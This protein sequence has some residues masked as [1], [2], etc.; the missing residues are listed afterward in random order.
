[1]EPTNEPLAFSDTLSAE[2]EEAITQRLTAFNLA[3][4]GAP[5]SAPMEPQPVQVAVRDAAGNLVGGLIGTSHAIPYWLTVSVIWVDERVRGQGAGSELMRRA[6]AIARQRGCRYAR[7]ATSQYQA[8]G[9]Y[10]KLGYSEYGRLDDCPPGET[11][12]YFRKNLT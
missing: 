9:F 2:E 5:W 6:E 12:Y 11:V 3:H 1:M 4:S 7:L 8:P 10:T